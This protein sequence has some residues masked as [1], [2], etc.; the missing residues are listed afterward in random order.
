[1]VS[2]KKASMPLLPP[3]N[4][5]RCHPPLPENEV[6]GIAK[7]I[8]KYLPAQNIG[9]SSLPVINAGDQN[10]PR[11][12]RKAWD[13]IVTANDPPKL[14]LH[15]GEPVRLELLPNGQPV[16]KPLTENRLRHEVSRDAD[17]VKTKGRKKEEES[18]K[19]AYPP[20]DV[21]RD[22]LAS[23]DIP[24]P[25]LTAITGAPIFT[26]TGDLI[27]TPGHNRETGIYYA[28]AESF[29]VPLVPTRPTLA[30][31]DEAKSLLLIELMGDFPFIGEAERAHAVALLLLPF[32]RE[33]I[34]GPTPLHLITKPM[35]GSGATL[36]ATVLLYPSV[37][38]W[39]AAMTEGRDEDE[40]RKRITAAFRKGCPGNLLR[41]SSQAAR[42][43][44]RG[45]SYHRY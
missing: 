1:M 19:S 15:G 18:E 29:R 22:M 8:S 16:L 33:L 30:D 31:I 25:V 7:S 45:L 13:A 9:S 23:P 26:P 4:K 24:L 5:E 38:Q 42:F 20:M 34:N 40:S 41:Q 36:L 39:I 28:P 32:V 44:R 12:T 2:R 21:V 11:A 3:Y 35:P 10:L 27:V 17:W 6:L 14:F 37:G 43:S